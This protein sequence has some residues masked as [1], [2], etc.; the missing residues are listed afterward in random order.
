MKQVRKTL[1]DK[2]FREI[3][4]EQRLSSLGINPAAFASSYKLFD[5]RQSLEAIETRAYYTGMSAL[6]L[7]Y[8]LTQHIL[9][10]QSGHEFIP[11]QVGHLASLRERVYNSMVGRLFNGMPGPFVNDRSE[12]MTLNLFNEIYPFFFRKMCEGNGDEWIRIYPFLPLSGSDLEG[13]PNRDEY[14]RFVKA[15]KSD[16]IL[17]IMMLSQEWQGFTTLDHVLGVHAVAMGIGRQLA[18]RGIPVD[19]PILSATTAGHDIGKFGCR[20]EELKRVPYLHY[21]YTKE[22]FDGHDLPNLSHVATNHSTWDLEKVRMPIE[23]LILIYSDFRVKAGKRSDGSWGMRIYNIEDS[24]TVIRDMLDNMDGAKLRRYRGVYKLLSD[25]QRLFEL[26][27]INTDPH[28][29]VE[30]EQSLETSPETG[31]N[32]PL[33][34]EGETS[35]AENRDGAATLNSSAPGMDEAST[36]KNENTAEMSETSETS[37]NR[38]VIQGKWI[39]GSG[40]PKSFNPV[41]MVRG[42]INGDCFGILEGEGISTAAHVVATVHNVYL[43]EYLK[44]VNSL[45]KLFE[46]A[47]L[48]K[49][50]KDLRA[51]IR[52]LE[53]YHHFFTLEQKRETVKFL[54][55]L[56]DHGD[57]DIR[58][59]AAQ[60]TGM[61]IANMQERFI[62]ELPKRIRLDMEDHA[63]N[64]LKSILA[65]FDVSEFATDEEKNRFERI[66]YMVP[67]IIRNLFDNLPSDEPERLSV[68][69]TAL[70]I[71]CSTVGHSLCSAY[72]METFRK[73]VKRFTIEE[74]EEIFIFAAGY[75]K[76][77]AFRVNAI[78]YLRIV[79]LDLVH[80]IMTRIEKIQEKN[81]DG[82]QAES[83]VQYPHS[84]KVGGAVCLEPLLRN[85]KRITEAEVYLVWII[86]R[87]YPALLPSE[88]GSILKS[89]EK[90][91]NSIV[92]YKLNEIYLQDFKTNV[93]WFRKRLNC[94]LLLDVA[95]Q[96]M[97]R[98]R[99]SWLPM[100]VAGHC[101]N[102]LKVSLIEGTRYVAGK[103]LNMVMEF[104]SDHQRN[105]IAIELLR[106]LEQDLEGFTQYMP[107]FIAPIILGL[108]PGEF[109]EVIADI[110]KSLATGSDTLKELFLQT[111]GHMFAHL[112]LQPERRA[113]NMTRLLRMVAGS[114]ADLEPVA[115][116][117][118]YTVLGRWLFGSRKIKDSDKVEIIRTWGKKILSLIRHSA[119]DRVSFFHV[120]T[121]YNNI[122]RFLLAW[123]LD[124]GTISAPI[125]DRIYFHP[126]SFDPFSAGHEEL[127]RLA[128]SRGGEVF[129]QIDEYSWSK[130][131]LP[132]EIRK[133]ITRMAMAQEPNVFLMPI[134][135]PFNI[136]NDENLRELRSLFG[137]RR[138]WMM[139]GADVLLN[140]SAYRRPAGEGILSCNHLIFNRRIK[141]SG[142][143][144]S[145]VPSEGVQGTSNL[146]AS[147]ISR[148][149]ETPQSLGK[150]Q[151]V[152]ERITGE[153]EIIRLP[154]NLSLISSTLIRNY[155]DNHISIEGL[156]SPR[157]Q[158][159]IQRAG[160]YLREPE[161]K[162]STGKIRRNFV[163]KDHSELTRDDVEELTN[164]YMESFANY[165]TRRKE[166]REEAREYIL[167][168][169]GRSR[170]RV[171]ILENLLKGR[172]RIGYMIFHEVP[173][174][175]L[176]SFVGDVEVANHLRNTTSGSLVFSRLI[177]TKPHYASEDLVGDLKRFA[178]W[179]WVREGYLYAVTWVNLTLKSRDKNDRLRELRLQE[180][181]HRL[182]YV[183]IP[184]RKVEKIGD[185]TY[186]IGFLL[187]DLRRP[188]LY[189]QDLNEKIKHPFRRN[190]R[191]NAVLAEN[192]QEFIEQLRKIYPGNVILSVEN[193]YLIHQLSALVQKLYMNNETSRP[194]YLQQPEWTFA[195]S[196][197]TGTMSSGY[198]T[199]SEGAMKRSGDTRKLIEPMFV[200]CNPYL[201]REMIPGMVN[202]AVHIESIVDDLGVRK[203]FRQ[204]ADYG[205]I[206]LQLGIIKAFGRPAI[207]GDIV[208]FRHEKL[209]Y[210]CR[211][212][213]EANISILSV[214]TAI[215]SGQVRDQLEE[216]GCRTDC[217]IYIPRIRNIFNESLYYPY[218][219][220]ES[221]A[222]D[223]NN[224][225]E[226]VGNI[227]E[228][229]NPML[230][231]KRPIDLEDTG[232]EVIKNFSLNCFDS[233][234]NLFRILED[235]FL[236][237]QR[238]ELVL[239]NIG[240][241]LEEPRRPIGRLLTQELLDKRISELLTM[242]RNLLFRL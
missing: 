161:E 166:S 110:E 81:S 144:A 194:G 235:E 157:V 242:D 49:N 38:E 185:K 75:L 238:K 190:R 103:V 140:A 123:E 192:R 101:C 204:P 176:Y 209:E 217:A 215:M 218:V 162:K 6:E 145:S 108:S 36:Q 62:K 205:A 203:G 184:P 54:M 237:E 95:R 117:M 174:D 11:A 69:K 164:L 32:G 51:Y 180:T 25:L 83:V 179:Q 85:L 91:W 9:K 45:C 141:G 147:Q 23:S 132:R 10:S 134:E 106:S 33:S 64:P 191:L 154:E 208:G 66:I 104:L 128:A 34:S 67:I 5:I 82:D 60:L 222:L 229:I 121:C 112:D 160:F 100:E 196:I 27:D 52:I 171:I 57:D 68:Y 80:M 178:V 29:S 158:Q 125:P 61:V 231:Y 2:L 172:E 146:V 59:S 84:W 214:L 201:G 202:K 142:S 15:F 73:T 213:R 58:F 111:I 240:Q 155:L 98:G 43:M 63:V 14:N 219:A 122:Y 175:R 236:H 239:R 136:S 187:V 46:E 170:A 40:L 234:L 71:K 127:T 206:D 151:K 109:E 126:G 131:T 177:V 207:I 92:R 17:E 149:Y 129:V 76:S 228:G 55:E 35:F 118:A 163:V 113:E 211:G 44:D 72:L 47:R 224:Q 115:R 220:G 173:I 188:I 24:F 56:L 90:G 167:N 99:H 216:L 12:E 199:G 53:I 28:L 13:S 168:L 119:A 143:N 18:A 1:H 232:F 195:R 88:S 153:S 96:S 189:I 39:F 107:R 65:L 7:S 19:L 226:R 124:N 233:A 241:V 37:E 86:S 200:A 210:I 97:T 150:L 227:Q 156:V 102:L 30:P 114:L 78:Q 41:G 22:W 139:A 165:V 135:P 79:A 186:E 70:L 225:D 26:M 148:E 16:R 152:I 116:K 20:G 223:V 169:M 50:W 31:D 93:S 133:N 198:H 138:L 48:E 159:Y 105:E 8:E 193:R 3:F 74:L 4:S 137:S 221:L 230:P 182:G 120:T 21:Y 94:Y 130:R 42:E 197:P 183:L 181:N 87:D 89:I 77:D 212:A